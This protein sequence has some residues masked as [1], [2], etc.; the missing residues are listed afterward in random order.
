MAC[1]LEDD[2]YEQNWDVFRRDFFKDISIF[3]GPLNLQCYRKQIISLHGM[4]KEVL[5]VNLVYNLLEVDNCFDCIWPV[6]MSTKPPLFMRDEHY[7][8][9]G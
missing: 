1:S 8:D 4:I 2:K 6:K 9:P 3:K 7:T 5:I